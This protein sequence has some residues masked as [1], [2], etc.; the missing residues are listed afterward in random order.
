MCRTTFDC[1]DR[2]QELPTPWMSRRTISGAPRPGAW[3][4]T[5]S[6]C[7]LTTSKTLGGLEPRPG[8]CR[9]GT[10]RAVLLELTSHP[11]LSPRA[12]TQTLRRI[13]QTPR[14]RISSRRASP[15]GQGACPYIYHGTHPSEPPPHFSGRTTACES[16]RPARVISS[17][18]HQSSSAKQKDV[19]RGRRPELRAT[20]RVEVVPEPLGGAWSALG[21][22]P[23]R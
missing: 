10:P 6:E 3:T 17:L 18:Q 14:A 9:M 21:G 15:S 23:P 16:E 19:Y 8:P 20:A 11:A 12:Q 22:G 7:S 4:S 5:G 13:P 2:N 1:A